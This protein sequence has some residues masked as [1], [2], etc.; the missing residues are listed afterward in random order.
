MFAHDL[1]QPRLFAFLTLSLL[2]FQ[3]SLKHPH[4]CHGTKHYLSWC[5]GKQMIQWMCNPYL[6]KNTKA[7]CSSTKPQKRFYC[8]LVLVRCLLWDLFIFFFNFHLEYRFPVS[9]WMLPRV[10]R[11]LSRHPGATQNIIAC[12]WSIPASLSCLLL[13]W[14]VDTSVGYRAPSRQDLPRWGAGWKWGA[15]GTNISCFLSSGLVAACVGELC[16]LH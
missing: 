3:E 13:S 6:I 16:C 4:I 14:L 8:K 15:V 2:N 7:T 10:S 9:T 12:L 5:S 11:D 1:H